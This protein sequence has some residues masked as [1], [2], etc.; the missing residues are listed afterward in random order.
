MTNKL[1][2]CLGLLLIILCLGYVAAN[3]NNGIIEGMGGKWTAVDSRVTDEWCQGNCDRVDKN[4]VCST[5]CKEES[6]TPAAPPTSVANQCTDPEY[7]YYSEKAKICYKTKAQADVGS[8]PCG[9]WCRIEGTTAGV[10]CSNVKICASAPSPSPSTNGTC[11]ASRATSASTAWRTAGCAGLDQENCVETSTQWCKWVADESP[12]QA[13][14]PTPPAATAPP[15]KAVPTPAPPQAAAKPPVANPTPA[16]AGPPIQQGIEQETSSKDIQSTY[17]PKDGCLP[18]SQVDGNCGSEIYQVIEDGKTMNFKLCSYDCP[19]IDSI[20]QGQESRCSKYKCLVRM[21]EGDYNPTRT[22]M[23]RDA[24]VSEL[25][26][27]ICENLECY[28]PEAVTKHYMSQSQF[29]KMWNNA[30]QHHSQKHHHG[31]KD[32]PGAD[33]RPIYPAKQIP[34]DTS[35]WHGGETPNSGKISNKG[36][37]PCNCS[38]VGAATT[39]YPDAIQKCKAGKDKNCVYIKD[40]SDTESDSD[41]DGLHSYH[42]HSKHHAE[43]KHKKHKKHHK[44]KKHKGSGYN[45]TKTY[46]KRQSITGM[47]TDTGVPAAPGYLLVSP[48]PH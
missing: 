25:G 3:K 38:Y 39:L 6:A 41:D 17:C 21:S 9:T 10:G 26:H 40:A 42:P 37:K 47:F 4:P 34:N 23:S 8:A 1:L 24:M 14:T 19:D 7:P 5:W 15:P 32:L 33:S 16:P 36:V 45:W 2:V 28:N 35:Y 12:T 27:P 20:C 11:T 13:P 31:G 48:G 18:P 46:E 30:H 29:N 43:K 22:F 44:D